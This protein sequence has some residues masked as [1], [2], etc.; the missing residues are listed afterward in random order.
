MS[1]GIASPMT[2]VV[3]QELIDL[4]RK[5]S[6]AVTDEE[7]LAIAANMVGKIIALQD[8]TTMTNKRALSIIA[9]NIE[10]GNRQ[11]LDALNRASASQH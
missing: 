10:L 3:F 4:L 7:L 8:Q 6:S 5:H 9:R 2:E 11:A 1:N